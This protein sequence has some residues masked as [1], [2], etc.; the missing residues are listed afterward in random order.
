M[1]QHRI[2]NGFSRYQTDEPDTL[3]EDLGGRDSPY[4]LGG[5]EPQPEYTPYS[6]NQQT[7]ELGTVEHDN[8]EQSETIDSGAQPK[9]KRRTADTPLYQLKQCIKKW[10][11]QDKSVRYYKIVSKFLHQLLN[12][13]S[14][15]N[16]KVKH[17]EIPR[18]ER[19]WSGHITTKILLD[20]L[21]AAYEY[22]LKNPSN[23]FFKDLT[24]A[25]KVVTNAGDVAKI[26]IQE[27]IDVLERYEKKELTGDDKKLLC[28]IWMIPVFKDKRLK[29]DL[30]TIVNIKY[31]DSFEKDKA[32]Y[33]PL[34]YEQESHGHFIFTVG[35]HVTDFHI[36]PASLSG[37]TMLLL[38]EKLWL[39]IPPT[40]NNLKIC[41]KILSDAGTKEDLFF[42]KHWDS[43]EDKQWG[44]MEAGG[45]LIVPAN[46]I[47]AVIS[48]SNSAIFGDMF[49]DP[50]NERKNISEYLK[51]F[52]SNNMLH[53]P[54]NMS[55]NKYNKY[56]DELS[57]T[58]D[59]IVFAW[60]KCMQ[61]LIDRN[62]VDAAEDIK[63][64][65]AEVDAYRKENLYVLL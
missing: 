39:W 38:G 60:E 41:A 51:F 18:R 15:R 57:S 26:P 4:E 30:E 56:V 33:V 27:F 14:S 29:T 55:K 63:N 53:C 34:Q 13:Y 61:A 28:S 10:E 5:Y 21:R 20:H 65:L 54:S 44:Y 12:D 36:D 22:G 45:Y 31:P 7:L 58:V 43:F 47:H 32:I 9:K 23:M 49:T 64:Q 8:V 59:D 24:R 16:P 25:E 3:N 11:E 6:C 2:E 46:Y 52:I 1:Q 19:L 17:I 37:F 35:A 50:V 42:I 40:T 62:E 48:F